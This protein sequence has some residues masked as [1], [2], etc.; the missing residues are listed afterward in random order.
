MELV[1]RWEKEKS[2]Y[3]GIRERAIEGQICLLL[4]GAWK[5]KEKG[6]KENIPSVA[7]RE[8]NSEL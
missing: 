6:Q 1:L 3:Y 7:G 4:P 2:G 5:S 8:V